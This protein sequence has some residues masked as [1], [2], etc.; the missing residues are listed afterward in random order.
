MIMLRRTDAERNMNRFY[1]LGLM[2]TL[3]GEWTLTIE[4]GRIG[5]SGTVRCSTYADETLCHDGSRPS[6]RRQDSPRLSQ[7]QP[8]ARALLSRG[9]HGGL[10]VVGRQH[11]LQPMRDG[12]PGSQ[13]PDAI[14]QRAE[15]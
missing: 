3:F 10:R 2:P 12:R 6:Y 7:R 14:G 11:D 4:W 13:A 5:S 1:A 9:R 8:H 15:L